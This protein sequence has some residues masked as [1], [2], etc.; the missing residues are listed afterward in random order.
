MASSIGKQK[1]HLLDGL[2]E[3]IRHM[4]GIQFLHE[5]LYEGL[6]SLFKT[7][8]EKCL[9][10]LRSAMDETIRLYNEKL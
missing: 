1:W 10:R 8:Y 6:R 3:A 4:R 9:R 5:G 7:E 2:V